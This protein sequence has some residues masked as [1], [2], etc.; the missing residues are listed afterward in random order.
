[1]RRAVGA[2]RQGA[3]RTWR[4]TGLTGLPDGSITSAYAPDPAS[5]DLILT[6]QGQSPQ[7]SVWGV[8]WAIAGI[9]FDFNIVLPSHSGIKVTRT[10]PVRRITVDYP[11][12][13]EAQLVIIEGQGRGFY[14]WADDVAGRFKRLTLTPGKDGWQLTLTTINPAP[15][16]DLTSDSVR[17]R[18]NVY[19]GDWRIPA[20]RYRDLRQAI[21]D[22]AL[23]GEGLDEVT[24]RHETFAQR[25]SWGLDFVEGTWDRRTLAMAHP[26]SSYLLRPYTI[27]YGYLGCAPPTTD[28]LY[29]AWNEDYQNWGV[30]PTLKPQLKQVQAPTGFSQQFFPCNPRFVLALVA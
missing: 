15:F 11:I 18:L 2:E 10:S 3:D 12:G 28:P 24:Y 13:W 14:V 5:G 6:Q 29:A 16:D 9:P 30:I 17:W 8:S 26:I 7:K 4:Y 27:I 23:S 1:M 19:E 21:P 22:V 25:H 20:R